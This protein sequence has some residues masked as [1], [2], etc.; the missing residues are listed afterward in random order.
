MVGLVG[1][2]DDGLGLAPLM[3]DVVCQCP[4]AALAMLAACLL[5]GIVCGPKELVAIIKD[6]MGRG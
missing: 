3:Y 5:V 6:L 2:S 1:R 4:G